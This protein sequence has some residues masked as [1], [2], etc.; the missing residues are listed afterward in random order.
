MPEELVTL[1]RYRDLPE[2]FVARSKLDSQE[3]WCVLV[4]DNIVRL[5]WFWSNAVGGVRLQ[6]ADDDAEYALSL[7]AEEIPA[8]FTADETG[9]DYQQPEC[10]NCHSRDVG[11]D[12]MYKGLALVSLCLFG[13]PLMSYLLF[14]ALVPPLWIPK[15][16]WKC[17]DCG[18][19]WS[20]EYD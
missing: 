15:K 11:F 14:R 13:L 17:E 2:A 19:E 12:S 5:D 7:L 6:V 10:P 16:L 1:W 4:D 20:A 18:N 8:G 3:V 9:E